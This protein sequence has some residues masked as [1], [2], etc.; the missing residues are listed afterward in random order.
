M[1]LTGGRRKINWLSNSLYWSIIL[2]ILDISKGSVFNTYYSKAKYFLN[3][4]KPTKRSNFCVCLSIVTTV[5]RF[6]LKRRAEAK[7]VKFVYR[8]SFSFL[9]Y[10][11]LH[12]FVFI[13]I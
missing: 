5:H 4:T 10:V 7:E 11:A 8:R 12:L 6:T 3:T 9:L 1:E 2:S 13:F